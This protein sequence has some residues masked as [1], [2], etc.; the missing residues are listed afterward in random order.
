M[1]ET[2]LTT[3][4]TP[5][6]NLKGDLAH[7]DW[8]F[9]L[10]S[11]Q[12]DNI[13]CF[14]MPSETLLSSLSRMGHRLFVASPDCRQL[15]ELQKVC[16]TLRLHN[17]CL[18]AVDD[19]THL[20]FP[21]NSMALILLTDQQE[22]RKAIWSFAIF[23][24]LR[25][26]V[27]ANGVLY[28]EGTSLHRFLGW[29]TDGRF[30]T[31]G[32]ATPQTFW[33]T[34]FRGEMRTALPLRDEKIAHYFF[35]NVMYGL[36]AKKRI[37]SRAGVLLSRLGLLSY[38]TP[39]RAV[40]LPCSHP[41][42]RFQQPPRYLIALAEKAGVNLAG[43]RYGFSARGKYNSN[44][45]IFYLFGPS[46]KMPEI[47]IKM[48][49]A[50]A[51]NTRL[52]N[53]YRTLALLTAQHSIDPETYPQP[54]FFGYHQNLA[55]LGQKAV[56]GH[57]F[58]TCTTATPHCPIA[59]NAIDWLVHL[60]TASVEIRR[61]ASSEVATTM[62]Q[63]LAQF[64]A[65][66]KLSPTDIRFLQE[67]LDLLACSSTPFPLVL[68]H[69]DP[70]TWNLLVREQGRVAFIDWEAGES[71]G[72]PLWDLFYFL[73]TYGSWIARQRGQRHVLERFAW[74]FLRASPLHAL[75]VETTTRYCARIGLEATL[76]A[77]LFYTCWMHRALKE[78]TR[79]PAVSLERGHY[80]KILRLCIAQRHAPALA[81]FFSLKEGK[82]QEAV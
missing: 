25:R 8:R 15:Q 20:P 60:G 69:G 9:L 17:V 48:T 4:Y 70:G 44:K 11:L 40:L 18:V 16:G 24:E 41:K 10:P 14:G 2:T 78:A 5:G 73:Y 56:P 38:L 64:T 49:R 31:Y 34:P 71:Q 45:V 72:M 36:T 39:R 12:L 6:T 82:F 51:F 35:T 3:D 7:A 43:Y 65:L 23:S 59:R 57:P 61:C 75:L 26:I 62:A 21:N 54:L 42:G 74:H 53:E 80:I 30:S 66:Y 28:G 46:G 58:R 77:P 79:L 52:E 29:W 27:H 1:F 68:Q 32:F 55:V 22:S 19:F 37:V 81:A 76:V 67:Q 47:I 63:L 33:L 50:P 13:L